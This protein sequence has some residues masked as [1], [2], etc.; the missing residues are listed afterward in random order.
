MPKNTGNTA[1]KE[2]YARL[3]S[4]IKHPVETRNL[5]S[6]TSDLDA[7]F[8]V[9]RISAVGKE[10]PTLLDLGCG[11]GTILD[12]VASSFGKVVAVDQSSKFLSFIRKRDNLTLVNQ[13]LLTLQLE[14]TF[15]LVTAFGTMHYFS[16]EEASLVYNRVF[17]FVK[18][19][20]LFIVKNQFG[21]NRALEVTYSKEL[22]E[23]YYA[24]YRTTQEEI[25]L[26]CK[27]G[28][29]LVGLVDIYP[30]RYNR[31]PDTHFYALVAKRAT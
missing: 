22:K 2:F 3:S 5:S 17:T 23:E 8:I 4:R 30:A 11:A 25:G 9:G 19:G 14:E 10:K 29:F 28:F 27:A 7:E 21:V 13:D 12:Q 1:A 18:P 6:D 31:W 24:Q 26:L 16:A 20:G 15:D